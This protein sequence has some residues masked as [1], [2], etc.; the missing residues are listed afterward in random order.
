MLL[1]NYCEHFERCCCFLKD[2][3]FLIYTVHA[4]KYIHSALM[5]FVVCK[6]RLILPRITLLVLVQSSGPCLNIKT[7]FGRYGDPHVKDKL[8]DRLIFNM[9]IPILVRRYLYI[10]TAPWLLQ[11]MTAVSH[12]TWQCCSFCKS[13]KEIKIMNGRI[14]FHTKNMPHVKTWDS[15]I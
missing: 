7:V 15:L 1:W 8:W 2:S 3:I 9:G 12:E 4:K 13:T 10:E 11:H 5:C 14:R 6:L